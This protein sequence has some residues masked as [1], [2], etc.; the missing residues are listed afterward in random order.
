MAKP[1]KSITEKQ[2]Q[3]VMNDYLIQRSALFASVLDNKH[4]INKDCGYPDKLGPNEYA[5]LYEREGLATRA[6]N[7]LP[8]ESWKFDPEIIETDDLDKETDFEKSW[9]ALEEQLGM[10][11]LMERADKLSGVGRFGVILLGLND[12]PDMW[13]PVKG[14][15]DGREL[16]PGDPL[17]KPAQELRLLYI[18]AFSED[19]VDILEWEK[20]TKSPRYGQPTYYNINFQKVAEG[21]EP[22]LG[23]KKVHWTRII[24]IADNVTNNTIYGTP[25]MQIVFNRLFDLRKICGGSGEMFWRGGFP[26]LGF[27]V[28]PT[29]K[30]ASIDKESIRQ[31]MADYSSG[32]NR[33]FAMEGMEVNSMAPTVADPTAH[34]EMNLKAVAVSLGVPYRIFAGSEQAVLASEQDKRSWNERLKKRQTKQVDPSIVKPLVSRLIVVGV[35]DYPKD[36]KFIVKWQD[37]NTMSDAERATN[38]NSE[39]TAIVAYTNSQGADQMVPPLEYMTHVLKWD[40]KKAQAILKAAEEHI[41]DKL[42]EKLDNPPFDPV[43]GDPLPMD[44]KTGEPLPVVQA[45]PPGTPKPK[46]GAGKL[47]RKKPTLPKA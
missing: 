38:A 27:K 4:K 42:Q 9:L 6:V 10:Y 5:Q 43:T 3:L 24:H 37:L 23:T 2:A 45:P 40:D 8:E 19:V 17:P 36:G 29:M 46:F 21:T 7:I 11:A 47:P 1:T 13:R 26:G 34:F 14:V 15:T 39:T 28:D 20:D 16:K 44:P 22:G 30:A 32:L 41:A 12:S 31:E 18:R 35:L 25:R 33:Y